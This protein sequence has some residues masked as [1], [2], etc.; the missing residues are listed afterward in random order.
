[1]AAFIH[2]RAARGQVSLSPTA[3]PSLVPTGWKLA[4]NDP[5]VNNSRGYDWQVYNEPT[6][7]GVC[8]FT[9]QGYQSQQFRPGHVNWCIAQ[10]TLDFSTLAFQ[11]QMTILQGDCGGL[12]FRASHK[13]ATFYYFEVCQDGTYHLMLYSGAHRLAQPV[14]GSRPAG[15]KT[16]LHQQNQLLVIAR[17]NSIDLYVNN[18][19]LFSLSESRLSVGGVALAADDYSH[20]T[21]AAFSDVKLWVP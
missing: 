4:L 13:N 6:T 19:H 11:A 16:G 18:Q 12:V 2:A 3:T 21:I 15:M 1:M 5:L 7:D 20:T 9:S 10:G 14:D 8:Q 17:E